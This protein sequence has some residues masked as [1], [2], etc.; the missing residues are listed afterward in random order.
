MLEEDKTHVKYYS[1]YH[2]TYRIIPIKDIFLEQKEPK[3]GKFSRI[4]YNYYINEL[5]VE[6]KEYERIEKLLTNFIL[7]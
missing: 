7:K 1:Y 6:Q 5:K 3:E 2:Q 4:E